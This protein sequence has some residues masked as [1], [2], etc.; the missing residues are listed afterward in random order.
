MNGSDADAATDTAASAAEPRSEPVDATAEIS[1]GPVEYGR[2]RS[3]VAGGVAAVAAAVAVVVGVAA[4]IAVGGVVEG[5]SVPS[6]FIVVAVMVLVSSWPFVAAFR[7]VD[8]DGSTD[9][10]SAGESGGFR[11]LLPDWSW[12]RPWWVGVGAAGTVGVG[13]LLGG[14]VAPYVLFSLLAVG[15][16]LVFGLS[17]RYRLDPTAERFE[18]ASTSFDQSWSRSLRWLVGLRRFDLGPMSLLVCSNRGKRWYEGVHLLPVPAELAPEVEA[19]LREVV[20]RT[21]PPERIDRDV[22]IIVAGVGASMLGVGPLLY[23]VSGEA[24]V[25][26]LIVGPSGL[27][28][29]GLLIHSIRG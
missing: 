29:L 22:R 18:F 15:L 13:W 5:R 25:L 4:A 11:G 7:E 1:W 8:S 10:E 14:S 9:D 12:L 28:A 2:L 26:F 3:A 27:I 19:T 6:E 17:R 20:D 24:V 16:P 21:E 23:L